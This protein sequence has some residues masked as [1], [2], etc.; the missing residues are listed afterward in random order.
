MCK[1]SA[2]WAKD[3]LEKRNLQDIRIA[4]RRNY[5]CKKYDGKKYKD[6]K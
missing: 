3:Y 5:P 6:V 4:L 2:A 1:K